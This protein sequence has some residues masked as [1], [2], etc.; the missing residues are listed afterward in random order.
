M[1]T[2]LIVALYKAH[3]IVLVI[4]ISKELSDKETKVAHGRSFKSSATTW[5]INN[6]VEPLFKNRL[7]LKRMMKTYI[8]TSALVGRL[9]T[10]IET[11]PAV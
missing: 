10:A 2:H 11:C 5:Q 7:L 6:K 8:S 9:L 3:S 1:N 4:Y